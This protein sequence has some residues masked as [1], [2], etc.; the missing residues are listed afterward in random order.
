MANKR[1][2]FVFDTPELDFDPLSC[3]PR[4]LTG[5]SVEACA[6]DRV[7]VEARQ[8]ALRQEIRRLVDS[9]PG[10]VALDPIDVLCDGAHC[11]AVHDGRLLYRDRDHLSDYGSTYLMSR[12][13]TALPSALN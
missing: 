11:T 6:V 7:K 10:V 8:G 12:L 4:P 9:H 2:V 13:L 1:V 3:L 5:A